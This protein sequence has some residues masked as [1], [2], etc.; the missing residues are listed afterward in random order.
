MVTFDPGETIVPFNI[1][2]NDDETFE[3]NEKFNLSISAALPSGVARD[4]HNKT[5]TVIIIDPE[6]SKYLFY[7]VFLL[8]TYV[9]ING[10]YVVKSRTV[11]LC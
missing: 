5:T 6:D 3:R 1:S 10:N 8:Y 7:V 11:S 9:H 2:I 4:D